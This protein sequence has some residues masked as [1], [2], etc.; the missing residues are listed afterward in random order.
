M[1]LSRQLFLQKYH[2]R[3]F[4]SFSTDH[5]KTLIKNN[6]SNNNN[7]YNYNYNKNN[8]RDRRA[9]KEGNWE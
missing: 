2:L 6:N 8:N 4:T 1:A 3:C 7:N 5:R 9:R